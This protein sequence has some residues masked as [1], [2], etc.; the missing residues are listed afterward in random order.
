MRVSERVLAV[1]VGAPEG[2]FVLGRV[3]HP[4]V[5]LDVPLVGEHA[6]ALGAG[7]GVAPVSDHVALHLDS[8][9]VVS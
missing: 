7:D 8:Y 3:H 6:A 9:G 5:P 1:W 4:H 2:Q